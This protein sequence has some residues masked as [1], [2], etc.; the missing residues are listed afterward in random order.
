MPM[1]APVRIVVAENP[2]IIP[3]KQFKID[4]G[5]VV[6]DD[7]AA[8]I[9]PYF[10]ANYPIADGATNC[11]HFIGH[12]DRFAGLLSCRGHTSSIAQI[13]YFTSY[14]LSTRGFIGT[15]SKMRTAQTPPGFALSL[16]LNIAS[17][18]SVQRRMMSVA[19][20]PPKPKEFDRP[21]S[22]LWAMAL[23]GT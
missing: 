5:Q 3:S 22:K 23:L 6:A 9:F 19:L 14:L 2:S 20:M 16:F 12:F 7:R 8:H 15:P 18:Y 17:S 21:M 4:E 10:L 13:G 1:R 11:G